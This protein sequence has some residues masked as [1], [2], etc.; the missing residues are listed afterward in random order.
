[1]LIAKDLCL[2]FGTQKIFDHVNFTISSKQKVGL[3]GRNGAGK[4]TMLKAIS[5]KQS[6]D[7]GEVSIER[8]KK[9]AYMPQDMVLLSTK[10]V[11]DEAFSTFADI[12]ALKK[13]LDQLEEFFNSPAAADADPEQVERYSHLISEC[14][15]IDIP[16]LELRTR[17]ILQGLGFKPERLEMTVDQLSVGWKMRLVLAKLLLQDADLYLF[18]EP[19][20][21]LDIVAKDWFLTF[22]QESK[23]GFLLVSHDRYFLDHACSHILELDRGIGTMYYG[24]YTKYLDQKEQAT[25]LKE[26]AAAQQQKEIKRKMDTINRFKASAS[27]ATQMQSMMKQLEK[28]EIIEVDTKPGA[29]KFSFAPV[30]RSGDIVLKVENVSKSFDSTIL[31]KNVNF[32]INRGEKVALVAANGVGKTTL[33]TCVMG[34]LP[35]QTGTISFGYNV[36]P[37]L[38]EQD[39][40]KSLDGSKTILEEVERS[41]T[42]SAARERARSMLGAFLFPGDDVEKR[43]RVLSGG[44]KNRVAM[45]K[46]LL[47]TGNFLMLDEPTNHLDLESKDVLLQALQQHQGTILFVSHDRSFLDSLATRIIE[48]SPTGVRSYKGNYESYLYC[49]QHELKE[50]LA[51]VA[52]SLQANKSDAE[53]KAPQKPVQPVVQP[54]QEQKLGGKEAYERQK[55]VASL[56]RK[57]EKLE[58]ERIDI[59]QKLGHVEWGSDEYHKIESR[60][61][62]ISKQLEAAYEEWNKVQ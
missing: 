17:Q 58:A 52:P 15:N 39:Q 31:F 44:E 25:A 23:F 28:I 19:T 40:E 16:A 56:E 35:Y 1:M 47:T 49:K 36:T 9:I 24:N 10:T 42:T 21:H 41:C 29:V 7:G 6:L 59:Q 43:I 18:D 5:G 54:Q 2:T 8:G 27:K 11:I 37:V 51:F 61:K 53:K 32:E 46:V 13:E 48:L 34:K 20:N 55:K 60:L 38:F 30:V 33:L 3:V 45:V 22:L 4:S 14:S 26:R 50:Q 57:V 12:F 62:E